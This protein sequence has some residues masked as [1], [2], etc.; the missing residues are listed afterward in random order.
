MPKELAVKQAVNT[1][2]GSE[3]S[4]E[5]INSAKKKPKNPRTTKTKQFPTFKRLGLIIIVIRRSRALSSQDESHE[6]EPRVDISRL[7]GL[8]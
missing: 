8:F 7:T 5:G 4:G 1:F 6:L 2:K 3:S